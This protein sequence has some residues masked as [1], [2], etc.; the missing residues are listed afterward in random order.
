MPLRE[1]L[2]QIRDKTTEIEARH[3]EVRE[4][5][6]V[7]VVIEQASIDTLDELMS[8]SVACFQYQYKHAVLQDPDAPDLPEDIVWGDVNEILER[9]YGDLKGAFRAV[10]LGVD[11]GIRG[12]IEGISDSI[13]QAHV[14]ALHKRIIETYV[15]SVDRDA[16]IALAREFLRSASAVVPKENQ[17]SPDELANRIYKVIEGHIQRT[18]MSAK[19]ASTRR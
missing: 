10:H 11:G 4:N 3:A 5:R 12:L 13:R 17:V 19:R 8:M 7:E 1:M 16:K 6:P 18:G 14:K 9:K 15:P 2:K